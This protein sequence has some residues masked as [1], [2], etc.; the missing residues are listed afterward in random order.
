MLSNLKQSLF[1]PF[2]SCLLTALQRAQAARL[3]TEPKAEWFFLHSHF[4]CLFSADRAQKLRTVFAYRVGLRAKSTFSAPTL[5][6]AHKPALGNALLFWF[7]QLQQLRCSTFNSGPQGA[8]R[9]ATSPGS[10]LS[11]KR[12]AK[13]VIDFCR[14]DRNLSSKK[15]G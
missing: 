1:F 8:L 13:N 7:G 9:V 12:A 3:P 4:F 6:P 14:A 5:R 10:E 2:A 11:A 15:R